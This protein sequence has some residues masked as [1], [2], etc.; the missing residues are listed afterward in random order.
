MCW[1]VP[2][3]CYTYVVVSVQVL[4]KVLFL[5]CNSLTS[6]R[7]EALILILAYNDSPRL[8]LRCTEILVELQL[9][10]G[11]AQKFQFHALCFSKLLLQNM[12]VC[13]F[14]LRSAGFHASRTE[15]SFLSF[16]STNPK[17]LSPTSFIT[18]LIVLSSPV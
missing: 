9:L 16:H 14:V 3:L 5:S 17:M 15:H 18:A 10:L 4:I 11:T 12:Q 6:I 7:Q 13:C 2:V 8:F 1:F